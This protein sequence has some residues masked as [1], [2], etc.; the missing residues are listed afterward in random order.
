MIWTAGMG[1][2]KSGLTLAALGLTVWATMA[3][4]PRQAGDVLVKAAEG[5]ARA[6]CENA[7][8]CR[9]T[10]PDGSTARGPFYRCP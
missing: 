10:C 9:N 7:G 5:T 3:C 2:G 4:T 1:R 6:A 8:N